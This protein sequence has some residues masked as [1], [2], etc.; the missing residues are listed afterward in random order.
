MARDPYSILGVSPGASDEEITRAYRELAK[1]YHP[2][3]N[4][5]DQWSAERMRDINN[6]YQQLK[7]EREELRAE[8]AIP[9]L[10]RARTV[11]D[12]SRFETAAEILS[13]CPPP[14]NAEW[15]CLSAIAA[16]GM[17]D[18]KTALAFAKKSVSL[19]P[20]VAEYQRV[21][22]DVKSGIR[23]SRRSMRSSTAPVMSCGTMFVL[24]IL[25]VLIL[26]FLFSPLCQPLRWWQS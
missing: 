10:E 18:E 5:G 17:G 4:P 21:L 2:D 9:P 14:R 20:D 8:E 7:N 1:R 23:A 12:M 24:I 19:K 13:T 3:L 11:L 6:A 26:M 15:Y 25:A 16:Y 22:R